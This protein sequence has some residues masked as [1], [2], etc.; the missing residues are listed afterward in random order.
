LSCEREPA[1]NLSKENADEILFNDHRRSPRGRKL[2]RCATM[3]N[4]A[5]QI[6]PGSPLRQTA[7]G[8][9]ERAIGALRAAYLKSD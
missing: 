9:N 8:L 2:H 5:R 1:F 3:Q 6:S 4:A 7:A